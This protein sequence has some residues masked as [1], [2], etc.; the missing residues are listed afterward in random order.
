MAYQIMYGST[1]LYGAA[2]EQ[3]KVISAKL[4]ECA[5]GPSKLTV[6]LPPT[7]PLVGN[8]EL[9]DFNNFVTVKWD[10]TQVFAGYIADSTTDID[11]VVTITVNDVLK[12]L[13]LPLVAL[14]DKGYSSAAYAP[15]DLLEAI[16]VCHNMYLVQFDSI[17]ITSVS[18]GYIGYLNTDTNSRYVDCDPKEVMSPWAM[19]KKWVIDPYKAVV[20][21]SVNN[22]GKCVATIAGGAFGQ[23]STP[24]QRGVNLIKMAHSK[25]TDGMLTGMYVTGAKHFV[26][27][28]VRTLATIRHVSDTIPY[29]STELEV[30]GSAADAD[31]TINDGDKLIIGNDVYQAYL[32]LSRT[33]RIQG[34]VTT[35]TLP[36]NMPANYNYHAANTS[37]HPVT[38]PTQDSVFAEEYGSISTYST[39]SYTIEGKSYYVIENT[40]NV[41]A[42]RLRYGAKYEHYT[43]DQ[44]FAP[45]ALLRAAAS[46]LAKRTELSETFDAD[47][48]SP[49]FYQNNGELYRA[50]Y[51]V[52]VQADELGIDETMLI[53]K[54][55]IDLLD[56]SAVRYEIGY[57]K[58]TA[59][60]NVADLRLDVAHVSHRV[61]EAR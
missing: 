29:G 56:H 33:M 61:T 17:A 36:I 5:D 11:G 43:T 9:H 54:A 25:S 60:G 24:I 38:I 46:E 20:H 30:T 59:T 21:G 52:P 55:S 8:M 12:L 32:P 1:V 22:S 18:Y 49:A 13:D 7:H 19:L 44:W 26:R 14:K 27:K 2:D 42:K 47:A 39:R 34:N 10:S 23:H 3:R 57:A 41:S 31:V 45:W 28:T 16:R 48:V 6:S 37:Y 40:V 4:D 51:L 50:G 58:K 15:N 35:H 53:A